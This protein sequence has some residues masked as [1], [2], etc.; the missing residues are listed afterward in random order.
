[1]KSWL[2][3]SV[4]Q[5]IPALMRL[6]QGDHKFKTNLGCKMRPYLKTT[7]TTKHKHTES[8]YVQYKGSSVWANPTATLQE[9]IPPTAAPSGVSGQVISLFVAVFLTE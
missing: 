1:M 9:A 2:A 8:A 6:P 3:N 7:T 4:T 5:S